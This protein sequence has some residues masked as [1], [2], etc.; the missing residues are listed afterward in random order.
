MVSVFVDHVSAFFLFY[1]KTN[2]YVSVFLFIGIVNAKQNFDDL[3]DFL[4]GWNACKYIE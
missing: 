2:S 3:P 4:P 1:N